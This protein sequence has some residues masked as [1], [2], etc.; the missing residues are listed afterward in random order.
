MEWFQKT[1]EERFFVNS[2]T[3]WFDEGQE[4]EVKVV[5]RIVREEGGWVYEIGQRHAELILQALKPTEAK[6]ISI[7]GE[8]AKPWREEEEKG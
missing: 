5:N 4:Q 8:E 3:I 2:Q 6:A 1:L 7:L